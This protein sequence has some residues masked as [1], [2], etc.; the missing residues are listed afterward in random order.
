MSG[1]PRIVIFKPA[2]RKPINNNVCGALL[3]KAGYPCVHVKSGQTSALSLQTNHQH[4]D[5][6]SITGSDAAPTEG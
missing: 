1:V 2:A 4:D 5:T 6:N 3:K